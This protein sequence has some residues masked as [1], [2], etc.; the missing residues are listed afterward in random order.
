M[1]K[2]LQK[3]ENAVVEQAWKNVKPIWFSDSIGADLVYRLGCCQAWVYHIQNYII[4]VS[5]YN[6]VAFI[7]DKG[8]FYNVL[9]MTQG[10]T[11]T[12]ATHISKFR[13]EFQHVFEHTW[14]EVKQ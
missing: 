14:R 12:S 3:L 5:H 4:L 7:D 6:V 9:R 8:D 2:E 1:K 13:K 10:Y 11:R